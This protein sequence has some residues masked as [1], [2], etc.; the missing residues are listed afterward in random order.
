[1]TFISRT[2]TT[3]ISLGLAAFALADDHADAPKALP[4]VLWSTYFILLPGV[5]AA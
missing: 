3:F 4:M 2:I 1:M 5:I